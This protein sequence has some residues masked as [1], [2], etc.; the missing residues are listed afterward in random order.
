MSP[1]VSA[2]LT[3]SNGTPGRPNAYTTA[4]SPW[5]LNP[6]R[7]RIARGSD[8]LPHRN[9]C[10]QGKPQDEEGHER[11][12]RVSITSGQLVGDTEKQRAQ[13]AH[14][15]VAHLVRREVLGLLP[16]RDEVG[17]ERAGEGAGGAEG[18]G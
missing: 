13:P 2:S 3:R 1:S 11:D 17:E 10:E 4:L 5:V 14:A 12:D 15:P 16:G 8:R 18:E 6:L 9:P 7:H